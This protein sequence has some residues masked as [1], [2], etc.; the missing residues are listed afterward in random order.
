M[1]MDLHLGVS[2]RR[3]FSGSVGSTKWHCH[4]KRLKLTPNWVME[5][6]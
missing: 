3:K 1:K 5:P 6:P 4:P 2:A